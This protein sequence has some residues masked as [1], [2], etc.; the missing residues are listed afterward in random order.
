M[1]WGGAALSQLFL[2]E[3]PCG[4]LQVRVA[5]TGSVV[6]LLADMLVLGLSLLPPK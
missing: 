4:L 1:A 6:C 5:S 2:E 3:V